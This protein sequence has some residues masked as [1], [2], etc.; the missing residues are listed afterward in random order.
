MNESF[1]TIPQSWTDCQNFPQLLFR[2]KRVFKHIL[3]VTSNS[4]KNDFT[5]SIV[6]DTMP[7][8]ID[9]VMK[10]KL[11]TKWRDTGPCQ[12]RAMI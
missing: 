6:N 5:Q 11:A 9:D 3:N 12:V 10:I 2:L 1:L 7:Y 4:C 8:V